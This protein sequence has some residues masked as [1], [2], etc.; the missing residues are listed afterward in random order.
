MT[1]TCGVPAGAWPAWAG[2]AGLA[3]SW[4]LAPRL[5]DLARRAGWV[6][7]SR[8]GRHLPTALGIV[9]PA[10]GAAGAAAG[11]LA[12]GPWP[13]AAA[14]LALVTA[15]A[16]FGLVDDLADRGRRHG[17]GTHLS[18]LVRGA[19]TGGTAKLVGVT[20]A[21]A[22]AGAFCAGGTGPQRW[23][24]TAAAG[25]TAAGAA[26]LIN[27]ADTAP[28]RALKV[29]YLAVVPLGLGGPAAASAWLFPWA[30]AAL[31]LLARDL[32]AQ[33]MLGDAGSY[34]LG[35]A[36]GVG[37]VLALPDPGAAAAAVLVLAALQAAGHRWSFHAWIEA[38]V[39]RSARLPSSGR[40]GR[41]PTAGNLPR[42]RE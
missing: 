26:N 3:A 17:W 15:A 16:L 30:A 37:L 2:A 24:W 13:G 40:A 35:A 4:W 1:G 21:A 42:S 11:S 38:L 34:A 31:P 14:G 12:A 36:L 8:Q 18:G 23:L 5:E 28:G 27:L 7:L 29:W 33:A 19:W 39:H 10:A 32:G 6:R 22:A 9:L 41:L 20:L 25:F